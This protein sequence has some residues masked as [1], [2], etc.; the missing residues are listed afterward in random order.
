MKI[1]GFALLLLSSLFISNAKAQ[2]ISNEIKLS[3]DTLSIDLN[4]VIIS[5][6]MFFGSKANTINRTG[7]AYFL[8]TDEIA[9][10]GHT[11]I[12]RMLAKVPGV[13]SYDEDGFGLRPNISLR[14]VSAERSAK[15]TIMEDGVL[16]APAPYSAPAAYYFPLAQRMTAVE[17]LKGSSQIEFGPFTTGGAINMVSAKIPNAKT[18]GRIKM[19]YGSFGNRNLTARFGQQL[20]QLSYVV[21][22]YNQGSNGFKELPFGERNTGFNKNDFLAK[23]R[24]KTKENRINPQSIELK[25]QYSDELSNETYLGLINS[26]FEANP[27]ARYAASANDKMK[28]EHFQLM[29]THT[30]DLGN[31]F[32]ITTVAYRNAFSRN[33]YKLND[34]VA[35]GNKVGIASVLNNPESNELAMGYLRGADSPANSLIL[36]NNNRK[37]LAQGIQTKLDKHWSTNIVSHDL[38]VGARLHYDEEDRFQWVDGYQMANGTLNLTNPGVQ[39]TDA[40]RISF[41]NAFSSHILYKLSIS[42]KLTIAPGVRYENIK[43]GREDFGKSDVERTGNNL[44]TKENKVD[45]FIPGIG[46]NYRP[47]ETI[48]LFSGVHK[49]FSPPGIDEGSL[50]ESSINTEIGIRLSKKGFY[51][52]LVGFNNNYSNLLG[53]DLAASGGSGSLTLFNAGAVRVNGIEALVNYDLKIGQNKD[54]IIPFEFSYTQTNSKFLSDFSSSEEIWGNVTYGDQLPYIPVHQFFATAGLEIDAFSAQL[55]GRYNGAIRTVAGSGEIPTSN[56]V[57]AYFVSDFASQYQ[58]NDKLQLNVNINN[59]FNNHYLVARVPSGLRPG[60]PFSMMAGFEFKF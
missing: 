55:S 50:P 19:S 10:Q 53:S 40:N 4:E 21:E 36:K 6:N 34:V 1:R 56:L 26:D 42:Q 48:A 41:A 35:D 9:K 11:D 46:L 23:L 22:G 20:G 18:T 47:N 3:I 51:A 5:A 49:G 58:L 7:S 13:N 39:G 17:V 45:Q 15:I 2:G 60:L 14:G 16:I 28:A 59:L 31:S 25:A 54:I 52:E 37:Y 12:T 33:W 57:R 32:R 8:S 43:L 24:F 38:E 44:Q 29:A 30:I 27:F